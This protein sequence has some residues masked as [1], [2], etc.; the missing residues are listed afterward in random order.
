[1][2][3]SLNNKKAVGLS[4]LAIF[5]LASLITFLIIFADSSTI[6]IS[7][8]KNAEAILEANQNAEEVMFY[9]DQALDISANRVVDYL[10]YNQERTTCGEQ[11]FPIYL[12]NTKDMCIP[13]FQ[14]LF[15]KKLDYLFKGYLAK[16]GKESFYDFSFF[17][18]LSQKYEGNEPNVE[19]LLFINLIPLSPIN[20]KIL[21]RYVEENNAVSLAQTIEQKYPSGPM[22]T[23]GQ[24]KIEDC[25]TNDC[26]S[27]V[28]QYLYNT[29]IYSNIKIN[30]VSGGMSPY[31]YQDSIEGGECSKIFE[32]NYPTKYN[33]NEQLIVTP[34]FDSAGWLWWVG[35]HANISQLGDKKQSISEYY[36]AFN[37]VQSNEQKVVWEKNEVDMTKEQLVT[38]AKPG[39][40]MFLSENEIINDAM[41]YIGNNKA[42]YVDRYDGLVAQTIS[43][44]T[45]SKIHSIYRYLPLASTTNSNIESI[46]PQ[47][48]SSGTTYSSEGGDIPGVEFIQ[49]PDSHYNPRK[50]DDKVEYLV[51]HYTAGDTINSAKQAF[52]TPNGQ[53]SAQYILGDEADDFKT[54]QMVLEKDAAFHAGC[55]VADSTGALKYPNKVCSKLDYNRINYD[56]IGIEVVNLGFDCPKYKKDTCQCTTDKLCWEPYQDEQFNRLVALSALI[57]KKL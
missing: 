20:I 2:L 37:Q 15:K 6:N 50:S 10:D 54:L 21:G 9:L 24:E 8:G 28:A 40:I 46:Q 29:Y 1:M 23:C 14:N 34:A 13:D 4:L 32:G 27:K 19:P 30:Y 57:I 39:D 53:S 17:F 45:Y 41:I 44:L 48:I 12:T 16:F 51:I 31:S 49:V 56:S 25:K 42:I 38:D 18:E 26:F 52:L 33:E 47:I 3:K 5:M 55:Y 43:S 11:V 7:I 35:K 22:G 36:A